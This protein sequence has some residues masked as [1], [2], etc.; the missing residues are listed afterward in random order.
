MAQEDYAAFNDEAAALAVISR[1][2]KS[3]PNPA[4]HY[5]ASQL[6]LLHLLLLPS[7]ASKP[8]S[9]ALPCTSHCACR[10]ESGAFNPKASVGKSAASPPRGSVAPGGG[11]FVFGQNSGVASER[12][13]GSSSSDHG[14][15]PCAR[16]HIVRFDLCSF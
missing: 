11:G 14:A 5:I 3:R 9:S 2:A 12:S 16:L 8:P 13:F 15:R 6:V 1:F 10:Y 7:S 4:A